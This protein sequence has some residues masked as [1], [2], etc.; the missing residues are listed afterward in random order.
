MTELTECCD[1]VHRKWVTEMSVRLETLEQEAETTL[2]M[3][4]EVEKAAEALRDA[5]VRAQEREGV[6]VRRC[7]LQ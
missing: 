4:E 3:A 7:W 5:Q 1:V 2:Q 6:K